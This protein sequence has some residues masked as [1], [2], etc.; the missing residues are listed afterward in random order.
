[1][2]SIAPCVERNKTM[3]ERQFNYEEIFV[4]VY[5]IYYVDDAFAAYG[6]CGL[7]RRSKLRKLRTLPLGQLLLRNLRP[8]YGGLQKRLF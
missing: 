2:R 1:M 8:L 5:C 3:K 7:F 4:T 6:I